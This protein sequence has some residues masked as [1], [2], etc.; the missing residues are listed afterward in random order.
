[1][2]GLKYYTVTRM[3]NGEERRIVVAARNAADA[4]HKADEYAA[5]LRR[6]S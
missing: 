5:E 2:T 1:M 3:I 4:A 6:A